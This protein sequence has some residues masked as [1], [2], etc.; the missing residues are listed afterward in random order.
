MTRN[1]HPDLQG[2]HQEFARM[3]NRPGIG[4]DFMHEVA[5]T[6][7]QFNLDQS[8]ADVPSAL[9]HGSRMLPLGRYLKRRLRELIGKEANAPQ[10]LLES[11]A[12]EMLPLRI[13]AKTDKDAPSLKHQVLQANQGRAA[14]RLARARLYKGR[15]SL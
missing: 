4:A 15:K 12:A 13:A 9:R 2:R 5:S 8:E 3:S 6:L 14:Q 11:L 10:A 1:D 7:L